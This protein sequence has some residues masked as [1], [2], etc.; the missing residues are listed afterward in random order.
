MAST[1]KRLDPTRPVAVWSSQDLLNG[2]PVKSLTIIL[3]TVGCRWNRC[4]M[5]GYASEG[6]PATADDLMVQFLAA[7]KK[8]SGED[9]V[10]KIY[11]SGSFLDPLEMPEEAR[12]KILVD[13][14]E[15]GH[16]EARHGVPARV[17]YS[18]SRRGVSVHD[19]H[20]VCHWSRNS[21]RSHQA[22]DNTQRVHLP[23]LRR[24]SKD[25]T[26][27]GGKGQSLPS[28]QASISLRGRGHK[29]CH[30]LGQVRRPAR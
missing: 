10:V 6:A 24:C 9:R 27:S 4:T 19:R 17:H 21:K 28:A 29:G 2:R 16:R 15:P 18:R 23:G 8:L 13:P 3:R 7:M 5:C 14:Q 25:G 22:E 11:T 26:R 1:E 20:R 30:L 12:A